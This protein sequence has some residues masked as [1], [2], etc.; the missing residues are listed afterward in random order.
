M[1]YLL[2]SIF[3]NIRESRVRA[4]LFNAILQSLLTVTTIALLSCSQS[5]QVATSCP[6]FFESEEL[7]GAISEYNSLSKV[8]AVWADYKP[9]AQ[10]IA[11]YEPG[12]LSHCVAE[13][14]GDNVNLVALTQPLSAE[15]SRQPFIMYQS[16]RSGGGTY[17]PQLPEEYVRSLSDRNIDYLFVLNIN[18]R[19]AAGQ[20]AQLWRWISHVVHEGVHLFLQHS[21]TPPTIFPISTKGSWP[22]WVIQPDRSEVAARCYRGNEISEMINR[23]LRLLRS[24]TS[25]LLLRDDRKASI[26]FARA[27]IQARGARLKKL[28]HVQVPKGGHPKSTPMGCHEAE[29]T[30]EHDEGIADFIGYVAVLESGLTTREELV[31]HLMAEVSEE[32]VIFY[33]IG[34]M[35]ALLLRYLAPSEFAAVS[36]RISNSTSWRTGLDFEFAQAVH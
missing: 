21:S 4:H 31:N 5:N 35:K 14:T 12:S 15:A 9:Y 36:R 27:Y 18:V 25:A 33:R 17:Y 20:S 28:E 10:T 16:S 8:G 26:E 1:K 34:S 24:A 30:F 22:S 13:V 11:I 32:D 19:R 29:V 6:E 2:C 23:E 7:K 3:R